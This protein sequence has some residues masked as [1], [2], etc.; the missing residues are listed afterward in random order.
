[1][2]FQSKCLR[3]LSTIDRNC[4][5]NC[6]S[7]WSFLI[8]PDLATRLAAAEKIGSGISPAAHIFSGFTGIE[9]GTG[10]KKMLE[11]F[12]Q[13]KSVR[14]SSNTSNTLTLSP[15]DSADIALATRLARNLDR[16]F[17]K[18][19]MIRL[20]RSV[21]DCYKM[22]RSRPIFSAIEYCYILDQISCGLDESFW[23]SISKTQ[24]D[25][26]WK[27]ESGTART[28]A[29]LALVKANADSYDDALSQWQVTKNAALSVMLSMRQ[30]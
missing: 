6:G 9:L 16:E 28:L 8:T 18:G 20:R 24:P 23:G 15:S 4:Q 1:M 22:V 11:L 5:G 2:V 14:Y 17:R 27:K 10:K 12:D 19:G 21:E 7:E 25:E 3:V 29:V 13:C 26:F 30:H